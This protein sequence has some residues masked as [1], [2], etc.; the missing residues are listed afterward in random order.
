YRARL[1]HT[2]SPTRRVLWNITEAAK[3]KRKRIVFPEGDSD[4][5]LRAAHAVIEAGIAEPVLLGARARLLDPSRPPGLW[6]DGAAIV[7]PR[8]SERLD[9]YV[10]AYWRKRQRRGVTRLGALKELR[11]SRTAYGMMMV[12]EGDADGLVAGVRQPYPATIRPALQIIGVR[13]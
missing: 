8:E 1:Y 6:L 5:I 4:A 9:G 7:D 11:R 10:D 13:P 12:A 3:A 2:I